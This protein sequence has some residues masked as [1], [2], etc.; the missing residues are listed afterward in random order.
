MESPIYQTPLISHMSHIGVRKQREEAVSPC[1]PYTAKILRLERDGDEIAYVVGGMDW[2]TCNRVVQHIGKTTTVPI[3]FGSQYWRGGVPQYKKR[4]RGEFGVNV[5][6][7]RSAVVTPFE[8]TAMING[9]LVERR[10][11]KEKD[12]SDDLIRRHAPTIWLSAKES[13]KKDKKTGAIL[14]DFDYLWFGSCITDPPIIGEYVRPV[15]LLQA[16]EQ[17]FAGLGFS[18]AT[19]TGDCSVKSPRHMPSI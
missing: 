15:S 5:A 18:R 2:L 9:R 1:L 10:I 6:V 12:D 3:S 13:K 16:E 11:E 8:W 4:A 14:L 19:L 7:Y 17:M